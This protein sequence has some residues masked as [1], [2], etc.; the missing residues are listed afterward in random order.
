ME[1]L[2]GAG[3]ADGRRITGAG[4]AGSARLGYA[5]TVLQ[6]TYAYAVP[7]PRTLAWIEKVVGGRGVCEVGAGRG[8]WAAMLDGRVVE[9]RFNV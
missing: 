5:Q 8:Y 3:A 9:F 4:A 2:V 7:S 6:E 1:P